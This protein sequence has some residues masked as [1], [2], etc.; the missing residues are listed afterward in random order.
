MSLPTLGR[1]VPSV[2]RIVHYWMLDEDCAAGRYK[3]KPQNAPVMCPAIIT[4]VYL[5]NETGRMHVNLRVMRDLAPDIAIEDVPH[6]TKPGHWSWPTRTPQETDRP[7]SPYM[8]R[9][10]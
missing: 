3:D 1:D 10:N 4:R 2:G 7:V 6:G 9:A 5:S 8:E